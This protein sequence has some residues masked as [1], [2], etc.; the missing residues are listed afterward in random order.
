MY[1]LISKTELFE[2]KGNRRKNS[3]EIDFIIDS[4][5]DPTGFSVVI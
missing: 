1:T 3:F 4:S 2:S 5:D